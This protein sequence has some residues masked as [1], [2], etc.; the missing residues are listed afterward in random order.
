[1]LDSLGSTLSHETV[2]SFWARFNKRPQEES[3][4]IG[5]AIQCL[6]TELSRPPSEKKRIDPDE[7]PIYTSV[8]VTPALMGTGLEAQQQQAVNPDRLVRHLHR[9]RAQ[10]APS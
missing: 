8:P 5:E 1:M 10:R 7:N 6:E 2:N 4:T 9:S 3:L